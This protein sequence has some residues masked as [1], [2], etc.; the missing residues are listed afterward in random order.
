MIVSNLKIIFRPIEF[1]HHDLPYIISLSIGMPTENKIRAVIQNYKIENH[2]L[3]GA[4]NNNLLIAVIGLEM[5]GDSAT[6][7]H[8]AVIS[9]HRMKSIGRQLIKY[10]IGKFSLK[11]IKAVTDEESV[12]FYKKCGFTCRPFQ[13]QFGTRYDCEIKL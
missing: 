11:S 5:V 2:K 6:I 13:G 1:S 9:E 10:V 7:K 3:F 8:I 4:F 12:E